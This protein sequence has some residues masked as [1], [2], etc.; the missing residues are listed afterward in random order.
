MSAFILLLSLA[1]TSTASAQAA[2]TEDPQAAT[3]ELMRA[4]VPPAAYDVMI[5]QLYQQM[6]A[7]I[8][9]AAGQEIPS[10][11]QEALRAAVKEVLPYK[12]LV[13]WSA[14]VYTKHF[15]H[16]EIAD[17]AAFYR[18]PTG[19]KVAR[20]LPT[21]SGEVGAKIGPLMM[22]RMPEVLKKHG[23]M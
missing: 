4:I 14:E 18:T 21:L 6:S 16:K 1:L 15:T 3:R 9:Q 13:S 2:K 11:K 19:K 17:M 12:E 10:D 20:L 8:R 5:E 23:L 7:S 22:T